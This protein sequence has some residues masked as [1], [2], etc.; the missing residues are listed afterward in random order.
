MGLKR[1]GRRL[2]EAGSKRVQLP[3]SAARV[4]KNFVF[5]CAGAWQGWG[6]GEG[7]E[8]S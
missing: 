6:A 2:G 8:E 5:H 3:K 1:R 4:S 7:G